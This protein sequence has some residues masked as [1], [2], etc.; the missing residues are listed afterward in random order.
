MSGRERICDSNPR[1]DGKPWEPWEGNGP[2]QDCGGRNVVWFTDSPIWNQVMGGE[3]GLLCPTCFIV[4]AHRAG[5][6]PIWRLV[7]DPPDY[8]AARGGA[9]D[10]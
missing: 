4:R 5:M 3:E 6:A 2:C 10:E 1:T 8:R 7:P 9:S